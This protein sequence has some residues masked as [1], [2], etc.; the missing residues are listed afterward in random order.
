[1]S[2]ARS[3]QVRLGRLGR[4]IL[5]AFLV[6][7]VV[8]LVLT[9]LLSHWRNVAL[10]E[11]YVAENVGKTARAYAADKRVGRRLQIMQRVAQMRRQLYD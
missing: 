3:T 8:P 5:L 10:V 7:A 2:D 6:V 4:R 9:T 11:E 1:M